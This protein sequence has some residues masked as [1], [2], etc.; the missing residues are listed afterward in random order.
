[1]A[2]SGIGSSPA[3][4]PQPAPPDG[5]TSGGFVPVG[6]LQ[7]PGASTG[8]GS[9]DVVLALR[10]LE[11][12][13]VES[14]NLALAA[15]LAS[16]GGQ[17]TGI[18]ATQERLRGDISDLKDQLQTQQATLQSQQDKL[19]QDQEALNKATDPDN[20]AD[21]DTIAQLT[22]QVQD[23]KDAIAQTQGAIAGTQGK[24]TGDTNQLNAKEALL[25]EVVNLVSALNKQ[26]AQTAQKQVV[27]GQT[28]TSLANDTGQI[29]QDAAKDLRALNSG[30]RNNQ[31]IVFDYYEIQSLIDRAAALNQDKVP[32]AAL[33]GESSR[34][35]IQV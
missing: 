4:P 2:V 10:N 7:S 31:R 25:G 18:L 15:I 27:E 6:F 22:Q 32:T 29:S 21:P 14:G 17:L 5:I 3:A 20:P 33:P 12:N 28:N 24:I 13:V 8:D 19:A 26:F 1:M 34:V 35:R 23:D 30:Q 9:L 16:L 11:Q